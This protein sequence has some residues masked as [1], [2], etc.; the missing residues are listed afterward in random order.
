MV[1]TISYRRMFCVTNKSPGGK[2]DYPNSGSG[3][4]IEVPGTSVQILWW[5][6]YC[7]RSFF[8]VTQKF[9]KKYHFSHD[10]HIQICSIL[11]QICRGKR[12]TWPPFPGPFFVW[13]WCTHRP[14]QNIRFEFEERSWRDILVR[15][16]C[17]EARLL[18]KACWFSQK[19]LVHFMI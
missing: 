19:T 12:G 14:P 2:L 10:H 7:S 16:T 3:C 13:S 5:N 17:T 11:L 4:T 9:L 1:K 15:S 8:F 6:Q 18:W